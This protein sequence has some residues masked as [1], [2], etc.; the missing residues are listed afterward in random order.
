MV[1][2][3][4]KHEQLKFSHL[5]IEAQM[6]ATPISSSLRKPNLEGLWILDDRQFFF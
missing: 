1:G 6:L 5:Q 2:E 3:K 4:D